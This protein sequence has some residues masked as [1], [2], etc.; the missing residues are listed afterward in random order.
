[1]RRWPASPST[2]RWRT[3]RLCSASPGVEKIYPI[4]PKTPSNSYA[5]RLQKAPQVWQT[6]GDT[7]ENS[8]VAIIDTGIDYTHAD[9]G[10]PGTANAYNTA[11]ANDTTDPAPGSFDPTKFIG[12]HDFAGDDYDADPQDPGFDPTPAPDNNP[13]DCNSHGTH[14][15]GIIAGYG[16]NQDGSTYTD[17]YNA[18]GGLD[19]S[20]YQSLFKIGPGMAPDAKIISYKVFGCEGS[21]DVVGEALDRAADPNNDGSTAD[22]VDVVNMSLGSDFGSSQDGDS[23]LSNADSALGISVV[24]AAGNGGDLYDIGGSPG[25]ATRVIGVAASVDAYNQIDTLHANINGGGTQGYGAQRS[26]AY[27]WANDPDISG[28]VVEMTDTSNKDGCDPF[29]PADTTAVNGK[30]VFLEWTDD[31]TVRRCGSAARSQNA[32]DAGAIGVVLGED[33]ETFSAGITGSADIPVV[34]VVK[35]ASDEIEAAL[36]ASQPVSVSGTDP[37]S[38]EQN[39]PGDD[40]KLASFSSRGIRNA[41]NVKPDVSAVGQSVFSAGMGT[42]DDG[43]SDSGTSMATPMVAGLSALVRSENSSWNPEQVKADIMNTADQ[44]LFTGSNHSGDTYAP[45]RVG[46]GRIDAKAALDNKVLAYVTDDPG[47]VSASFGTIEATGPMTLHKTIKLDNQ[48][49]SDETYDT[50]YDALTSV[51][52]ADYSVSPS[53][54]TVDAGQTAT[55]TLTLTIDPTQ[56]TK[57]IDPTVDL[58]QGGLPREFL[59]DASGRVL[60]APEDSSPTL[61][62]PVY[63]APRP[64]SVMTQPSSLDMPSGSIQMGS[65]PLSGTGVQPGLG[66]PDDRSRSW[67]ASSSRRRARRCRTAPTA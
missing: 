26:V 33:Q 39:V 36:D 42:G 61:R 1:M 49:G 23:I 13:L 18:L 65:L 16:E 4:A 27:D 52:G 32:E 38:F 28:S 19:A 48:G 63:S 8:T 5:V 2:R 54:V 6:Y 25:D 46:A 21:T 20:T 60:F 57:T 59:A 64:A 17:G 62:V 15:A 7:G 34:Q 35:S 29:D 51:P 53:Q 58:E 3:W 22:H 66:L 9:F 37:N 41:G 31:S 14:V 43:L 56:L 67:P 40:D 45:N 47:A 24:V 30:V 11:L 10:G 12:G 44:D 55:V 50:S